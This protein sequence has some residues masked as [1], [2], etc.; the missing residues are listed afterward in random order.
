MKDLKSKV[1]ERLKGKV[2]VV[3]GGSRGIGASIA[4]HLAQEKAEVAFTYLKAKDEAN[5]VKGEI[6]AEGSRALALPADSGN[7]SELTEAIEKVAQEFGRIDILV[8]SAGAL[9]FKPIDQFT[10]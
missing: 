5:A 4:R 9:L 7:A 8:N 2:A 10:I 3:T 1:A 6:E